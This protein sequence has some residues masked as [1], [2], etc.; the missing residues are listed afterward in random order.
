MSVAVVS[1]L[2]KHR[3][4]V[5]CLD[6]VYPKLASGEMNLL[7]NVEAYNLGI[8]NLWAKP[9]TYST[10]VEVPNL[11][12]KEFKRAQYPTISISGQA[13]PIGQVR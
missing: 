7:N 9:I 3:Q 6:I 2:V 1:D 11:A 12:E 4:F 5:K 8:V 13:F 10:T